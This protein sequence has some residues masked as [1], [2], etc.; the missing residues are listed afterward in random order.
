MI[1]YAGEVQEQCKVPCRPNT[2]QANERT[3]LWAW[4]LEIMAR[5]VFSVKN[6]IHLPPIDGVQ[7]VQYN[8]Q[9]PGLKR[10][11]VEKRESYKRFKPN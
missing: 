6:N 1:L 8:K 5:V 3:F 2:F 10:K 11:V 4:Q 7:P 9:D